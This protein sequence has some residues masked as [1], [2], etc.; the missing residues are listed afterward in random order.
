MQHQ[1]VDIP[2]RGGRQTQ[3]QALHEAEDP[4][5]IGA[6]ASHAWVRV[7]CPV[8]GWVE[9]DPTNDCLAAAGHVTLAMGRDYGDVTPMRGVIRGGG[10]H[11]LRV[12]VSVV[13]IDER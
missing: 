3:L 4:R 10:R 5:L 12:G 7:W 2:E 6:D 8:N 13:P 11:A 1:R 9:Y